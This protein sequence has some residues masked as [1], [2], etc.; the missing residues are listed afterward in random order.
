MGGLSFTEV[1]VLLLLGLLIFGPRRLPEIGAQVG[2]AIREFRQM[3]RDGPVPSPPPEPTG[4]TGDAGHD[5]PSPRPDAAT[6]DAATDGGS[7]HWGGFRGVSCLA[8][9]G[10][11]APHLYHRADTGY[12]TR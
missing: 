12:T 11:R 7:Q 10:E 4:A 3:L 1:A 2:R 8:R 9:A 5:R 6:R